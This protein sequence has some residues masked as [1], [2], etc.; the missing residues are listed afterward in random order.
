MPLPPIAPAKPRLKRLVLGLLMLCAAAA[1]AGW[2]LRPLTAYW[3]IQL[4]AAKLVIEIDRSPACPNG[5]LGLCNQ[6]GRGPT[7]LSIWRYARTAPDT[8]EGRQL[9]ALPIAP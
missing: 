6:G 4:G 7:Y 2:A 8:S 9:L 5:M 1:L 3:P